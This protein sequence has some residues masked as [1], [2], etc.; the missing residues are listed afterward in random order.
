M[1]KI[2]LIQFDPRSA[3]PGSPAGEALFWLDVPREDMEGL[4]YKMAAAEEL[5]EACELMYATALFH[6]TNDHDAI[7]SAAIAKAKGE[8]T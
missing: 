5:F 8:S 4:V 1:A 3:E 6:H 2:T 7:V